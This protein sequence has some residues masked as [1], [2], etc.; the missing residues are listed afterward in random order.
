[1][2]ADITQTATGR[3][4][5]TGNSTVTYFGDV[6]GAAGS[7]I[8]TSAGSTAVFMGSA[9]GNHTGGGVKIFDGPGACR[10]PARV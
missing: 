10:R 3:L 7:E 2:Y 4:I 5:T 9:V 8:R 6:T 1:V